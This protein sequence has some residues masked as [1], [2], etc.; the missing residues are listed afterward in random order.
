M[1][2]LKTAYRKPP[3]RD[4]SAE[5]PLNIP[6]AAP[7]GED[8]PTVA[9]E[10]RQGGD[11][12]EPT[13]ASRQ[14][15]QQAAAAD[16]A[17]FALLKQIESL[18][19]SEAAQRQHHA[20]QMAQ[21]AHP[22]SHEEKIA[23]WRSQGLSNKEAEW[24]NNHPEA[25]QFPQVTNIATSEALQ[26]G[27]ERDSDG[28]F[29]AIEQGFDRHMKQLRAQA[30]AQPTPEFFQPPEP[31]AASVPSPA[32]YVSAPVS[33]GEVGGYREPSPSQVRLSA[34]ELEIAKA[35][36]ISPVDYARNKQR[37]EREK[38]TGQRQ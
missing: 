33:R 26:A 37:L 18:R 32:S 14:Y 31:S 9:V 28:Y 35:S 30:A 2:R 7:D 8:N 20:A 15:E 5:E 22:I 6:P 10:I 17:K 38:R 21:H 1:S 23:L 11:E 3:P 25:V 36:K 27:H 19:Q 4:I 12:G 34:D 24:L 13:E 29:K 16:Q